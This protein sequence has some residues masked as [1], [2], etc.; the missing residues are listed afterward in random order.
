MLAY[1]LHL[2]FVKQP[3]PPTAVGTASGQIPIQPHP[4]PPCVI[5]IPAQFPRLLLPGE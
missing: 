2:P 4:N 3:V 5:A 1:V